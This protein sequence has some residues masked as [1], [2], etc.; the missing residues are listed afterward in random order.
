M[1][2]RIEII[3]ANPLGDL[4]IT[5]DPPPKQ[6]ALMPARIHIMLKTKTTKAFSSEM[7]SSSSEE[8]QSP[9]YMSERSNEGSPRG[10]ME[11]ALEEP[12]S[13]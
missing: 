1:K 12:G 9:T 6:A 7:D 2:P 3:A 5:A 10:S 4:P 13:S 8:P 11:D